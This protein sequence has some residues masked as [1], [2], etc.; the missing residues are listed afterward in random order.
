[1]GF[2]DSE[3]LEIVGVMPKRFNHFP[4]WQYLFHQP[5]QKMDLLISWWFAPL[6]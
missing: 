3:D 4:H 1:M 6:F 5:K 2:Q